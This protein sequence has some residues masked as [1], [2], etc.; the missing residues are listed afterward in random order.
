MRA[1]FVVVLLVLVAGCAQRH[2]GAAEADGQVMPADF[3]GTVEYANGS[4]PPPYHF[5]WRLTFDASTAVVEWRPGYDESAR[6]WRESVDITAEQR[7]TL[8]GRLR[9]LGVFGTVEATD[10]G[11]V[12]GPGGDIEVTADGR[13]YDPGPLG[14]S[15]SGARLLTDVAEAVRELVPADVWDGLKVKQDDWSARQPK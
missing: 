9:D 15:E 1:A 7:T 2:A 6:P 13:T 5:R 11:M 8:Y 14:G 12:G 4:V 10:D 3:A